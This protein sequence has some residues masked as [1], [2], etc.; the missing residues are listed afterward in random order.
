MPGWHHDNANWKPKTCPICSTEFTPTGGHHRFCSTPCRG[1]WKY[2]TG[3]HSTANQYKK[4]SGNWERYCARLLY[5][6]GRRRDKLTRDIIMAQLIRQDYRCA[7]T[8][9]LLTCALEVGTKCRT[10]ATVDR[11]AAGGAYTA[12][13]IQLVCRAINSF[14]NNTPL[15]E[16]VD[17]CR[18]VV[19]HY[20][21][22]TPQVAR[23]QGVESH[24]ETA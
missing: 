22:H 14:R 8:G 3:Q 9:R 2:V 17:W 16:F 11:I 18:A 7:I 19:N 12:D 6:G 15:P 4:I 23:G 1:K 13:N 10:N 5:Y 24:G 20:E 21:T